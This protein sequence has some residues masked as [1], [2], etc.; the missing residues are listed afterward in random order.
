MFLLSGNNLINEWTRVRLKTHTEVQPAK[1]RSLRSAHR[2][3]AEGNI[4][5]GMLTLMLEGGTRG[6][7]E[8]VSHEAASKNVSFTSGTAE[9]GLHK[10]PH[11]D[12]NQSALIIRFRLNR[13]LPVSVCKKKKKNNLSAKQRPVFSGLKP[14]HEAISPYLRQAYV[15]VPKSAGGK[16][17]LPKSV[18]FIG[19]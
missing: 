16:S 12:R 19:V 8:M 11:R 15:C 10:Q 17:H 13:Q 1:R 5:A 7:Y 4:A 6:A 18:L 2:F 3:T 9:K 14:L